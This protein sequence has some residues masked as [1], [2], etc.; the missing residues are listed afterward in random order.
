MA[1]RRFPKGD[2]HTLHFQITTLEG[3]GIVNMPIPPT[4]PSPALEVLQRLVVVSEF[5]YVIIH[6][7]CSHLDNVLCT[8]LEI[9]ESLD[10]FT[11]H[12]LRTFSRCSVLALS[13]VAYFL[14]SYSPSLVALPAL[15][16]ISKLFMF[17]LPFRIVIIFTTYSPYPRILH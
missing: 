8:F 3:N 11:V 10:A 13:F 7:G 2:D 15:C 14:P 12:G 6:Q 5:Y 9:S 17:L 1:L 16:Q 4:T